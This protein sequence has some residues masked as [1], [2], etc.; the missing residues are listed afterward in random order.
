MSDQPAS[1]A[2]RVIYT[3]GYD[4]RITCS[5]T[6]P[7]NHG[8]CAE[9]WLLL[10]MHPSGDAAA[11]LILN[12]RYPN[13]AADPRPASSV[14]VHVGFPAAPWGSSDFFSQLQTPLRKCDFTRAKCCHTSFHSGLAAEKMLEPYHPITLPESGRAEPNDWP[15]GLWMA[16]AALVEREYA[17]QAAMRLDTDPR[18]AHLLALTRPDLPAP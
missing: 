13:G 5:H 3:P 1:P 9:E 6:P 16:L 15:E 14:T 2:R 18:W 11:V 12:G 8:I 7:G 17:Q 10:A 4:C